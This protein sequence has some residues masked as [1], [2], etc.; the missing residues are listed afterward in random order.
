MLEGKLENNRLIPVPKEDKRLVPQDQKKRNNL[1]SPQ[2]YKV[3]Q[4]LSAKAKIFCESRCTFEEAA[5]MLSNIVGF[6][7]TATNLKTVRLMTG[8]NWRPRKVFQNTKRK[9]N[10]TEKAERYALVHT[11]RVWSS[12]F[13]EPLPPI[14]YQV[15]GDDNHPKEKENTENAD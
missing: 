13:N 1:T 12:R 4:A 9:R 7:V 2:I 14:F 11:L 8:V 3:A 5:E 15:F 10:S 6:K